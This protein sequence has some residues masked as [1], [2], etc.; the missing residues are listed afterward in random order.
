MM[1]KPANKSVMTAIVTMF[2]YLKQN[3]HS[4]KVTVWD[5]EI[6]SKIGAKLS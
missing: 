4:K 6:M 2:K 5:L 3:T 1:M